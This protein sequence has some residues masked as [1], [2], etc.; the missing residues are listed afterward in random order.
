MA[1]I[2]VESYTFQERKG[3]FFKDGTHE[4]AL[5]FVKNMVPDAV[6]DSGWIK[7]FYGSTNIKA[8]KDGKGAVFTN[9]VFDS[10]DQAYFNA[11]LG[12]EATALL[13]RTH[14]VRKR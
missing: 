14:D 9:A 11:L 7:T 8:G 5:E 12:E 13:L 2:S 3:L 6:Y 10:G 1:S 4:E